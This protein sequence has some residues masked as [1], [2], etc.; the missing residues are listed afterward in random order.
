MPL[1]VLDR[2]APPAHAAHEEALQGVVGRPAG[3]I[4]EFKF[5]MGWP[6][7]GQ[8]RQGAEMRPRFARDVKGSAKIYSRSRSPGRKSSPGS[9]GGL[10]IL[11]RP[12]EPLGATWAVRP[13][14]AV[15]CP[16]P[17]RRSAQ[18]EHRDRG[19][20]GTERSGLHAPRR[21]P[22]PRTSTRNGRRGRPEPRHGTVPTCA[23]GPRC[24]ATSSGQRSRAEL[25]PTATSSHF[26]SLASRCRRRSA[27]RLCRCVLLEV[28]FDSEEPG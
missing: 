24:I 16:V 3:V 6:T 18:G 5:V 4:G 17:R 22:S 26:R 8:A 23:V 15:Q 28:P 2:Q 10:G 20:A 27:P 1:R 14:R 25:A 11:V 19:E 9:S 13:R 21:Q 7:T 12:L